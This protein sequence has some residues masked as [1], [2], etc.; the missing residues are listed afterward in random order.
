MVFKQGQTALITGASSGI[1]QAFAEAL[2]ARGLHVILIARS[3][4]RLQALATT[5]TERYGI[6][7]EVIVADLG[8]EQ[9]I[10]QIVH[11]VK[12]RDLV[13][14]VL[15]NNAGF[16]NY[17]LFETLEPERDHKQIMVNVMA[18]ADLTHAFLP[19]MVACGEGVII[20]VASTAALMPVPYM[21]I[22]GASK[23]F[24]LS[25]SQ[26]L[27]EEYRQ[28]GIRVLALCPGTTETPFLDHAGVTASFGR[29]RLPE[30]VVAT[31]LRGV[32]RG[33]TVVVDGWSNVLMAL[34]LRLAPHR[35]V[36]WVA[37]R[38]LHPEAVGAPA[39]LY[40]RK[41]RKTR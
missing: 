37:G 40:I 35:L 13:V 5:L 10:C 34:I 32:E 8:Q 1:G 30:Q 3:E 31:G 36:A 27:A 16:G 18:V 38:A 20:N 22:Y 6:R 26:A 39:F 23:A 12:E 24:V 25:F 11:E 19:S 17:G 28:R 2:A 21:A 4:A 7:A 33:S 41:S 14:D 15:V 9:A 29:L